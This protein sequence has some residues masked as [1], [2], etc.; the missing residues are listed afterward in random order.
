MLFRRLNLDWRYAI[1][2]LVIVVVGV[3]LA[4][5]ADGWLTNVH[6]R[7][8]ESASLLRL[9]SDMQVDLED[10]RG[11]LRRTKRSYDAATWLMQHRQGPAPP[12]DSL[13]SR[14]TDFTACSILSS[15]TSEYTALKSSGQV[16]NL[17]DAEFRQRLV[18]HY[19]RYAYFSELYDLDC[20][21]MEEAMAAIESEVE[22]AVDTTREAWLI[23]VTGDAARVL[24]NPTFQ[25]AVAYAANNRYLRM[26]ME[27]DVIVELVYLRDRATE[28]AG[29]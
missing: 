27:E 11:N 13:S 9:A 25:R 5:A 7:H 26:E 21:Y 22:F 20:R 15:N 24:R 10:I 29:R 19:E 2:E 8:D 18:D 1:T 3:L 28:L 4:L 23:G 12:I 14:L 16:A 6:Q 17:R